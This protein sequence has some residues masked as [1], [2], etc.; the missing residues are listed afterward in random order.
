VARNLRL[1]SLLLIPSARPPHKIAEAVAAPWHRFAM[2]VLGTIDKPR[3]MVSALEIEAPEMP[4]TYETMMRLREAYGPQTAL[5]FVLGSDS[6]EELQYW[7]EPDRI[8]QACSLVVAGRPGYEM[9]N[10]KSAGDRRIID[11]RG[12]ALPESDSSAGIVYLT[13]YVTNL[14]SST[15]IR[16]RVREGGS[17]RGLVP[18]L[19]AD[20][21]DKYEL[22]RSTD[23]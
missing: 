1:D 22:Y 4:Y 6:Y 7:K 23:G 17:A 20:F 16:R 18:D 11:L 3:L 15:E 14:T 2:A 9:G 12:A 10:L 8:L 19:V 21:I 13:D 5:F